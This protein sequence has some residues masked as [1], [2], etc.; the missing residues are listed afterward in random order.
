[1]T[2]KDNAEAIVEKLMENLEQ[3]PTESKIRRE[4]VVNIHMLVEKYSPSKTWFV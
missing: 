3:L 1:M 4:L 2:N